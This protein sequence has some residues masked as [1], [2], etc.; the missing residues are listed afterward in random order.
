MMCHAKDFSVDKPTRKRQY[1]SCHANPIDKET[2]YF[3]A[4]INNNFKTNTIKGG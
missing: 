1:S 2:T 3:I 4:I